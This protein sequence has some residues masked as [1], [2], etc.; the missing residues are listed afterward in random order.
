MQNMDLNFIPLKVLSFF[1]FFRC[2]LIVN[3]ENLPLVLFFFFFFFIY[4]LYFFNFFSLFFSF[5]FLLE[6][7]VT[8]I[9]SMLLPS[10]IDLMTAWLTESNLDSHEN[11]L[12]CKILQGYFHF[13][14]REAGE[15]ERAKI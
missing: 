4:F 2:L 15:G 7:L 10:H 6:I 9:H 13:N 11:N 5:L 8:C 12:P 1:F 14:R 3:M